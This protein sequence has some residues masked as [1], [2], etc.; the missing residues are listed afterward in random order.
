MISHYNMCEVAGKSTWK[1][2]TII[3]S[4]VKLLI[5]MLVIVTR[6]RFLYILFLIFQ[7]S[8][9]SLFPFIVF[10][11]NY[12]L[13][14]LFER[15]IST[16]I[17]AWGVWEQLFINQGLGYWAN[18]ANPTKANMWVSMLYTWFMK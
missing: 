8:M 16:P 13:I 17:M 2:K 7:F 14:F 10:Q 11:V 1:N 9:I 5:P 12:K 18:R 3:M 15:N 6:D 4:Q